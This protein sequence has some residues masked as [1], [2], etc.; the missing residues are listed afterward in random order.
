MSV[1]RAHEQEVSDAQETM[2]LIREISNELNT[3]LDSECLKLIT[4]LCEHGV[5]PEALATAIL[6]NAK[7]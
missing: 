2:T 1:S 5:Q 3:G 4:A 6:R 7:K